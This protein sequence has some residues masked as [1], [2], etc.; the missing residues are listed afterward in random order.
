ME[1]VQVYSRGALEETGWSPAGIQP[2]EESPDSKGR[3]LGNAQAERSDT[4]ATENRPPMAESR[5]VQG[6]QRTTSS[7]IRQG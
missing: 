4:G 2:R 1:E 5:R 7:R 6:T 3:V